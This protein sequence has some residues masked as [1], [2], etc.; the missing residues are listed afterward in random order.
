MGNNKD[1]KVASQLMHEVRAAIID[2][3][4]SS[5]TQIDPMI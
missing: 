3:Q 1:A 4:V 2:C 5:K